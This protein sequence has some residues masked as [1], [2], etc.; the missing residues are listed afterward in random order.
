MKQCAAPPA[1]TVDR[2]LFS[3]CGAALSLP[4]FTVLDRPVCHICCIV[5]IAFYSCFTI[6]GIKQLAKL[7][8]DE[9]PDVSTSVDS[10]SVELA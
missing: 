10:E 7:L 5:P 4:L 9:A 3:F 6:M 1:L 8:S 2:Q